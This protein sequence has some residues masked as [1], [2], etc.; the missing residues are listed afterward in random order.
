M[1]LRPDELNAGEVYWR[2]HNDWLKASTAV[3][4]SS[5]LESGSHLGKSTQKI[6]GS[7]I[8][9]AVRIHDN[10]NVVLKKIRKDHHPY[11]VEI[12]SSLAA[13]GSSPSNHCIPFLGILHPSDDDNTTI[14]VMSLLR[15]W[16]K[17]RFDTFGEV[18]D[19]SVRFSK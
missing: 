2:D 14:L 10:A 16:D 7:H 12:A 5:Q 17:P 1:P 19:F 8:I 11:E 15:E 6:P 3:K 13:L 9:D 18:V 4:V